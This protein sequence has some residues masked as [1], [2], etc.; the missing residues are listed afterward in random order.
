MDRHTD[1]AIIINV[2]LHI[3]IMVMAYENPYYSTSTL[4]AELNRSPLLTLYS[5]HIH[6]RTSRLNAVI[7]LGV[8][9]WCLTK[10]HQDMPP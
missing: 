7:N 9:S 10:N 1:R 6:L 5:Q 8:I 2:H 4:H 3:E